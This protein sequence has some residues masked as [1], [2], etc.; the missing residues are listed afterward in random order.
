MK[1]KKYRS[2]SGASDNRS[3]RTDEVCCELEWII[4]VSCLPPGRNRKPFV[5]CV[6]REK[7]P[8]CVK[9]KKT[10]RREK[11]LLRQWKQQQKKRSAWFM[12]KSTLQTVERKKKSYCLIYF[13]IKYIVWDKLGEEKVEPRQIRMFSKTTKKRKWGA[14]TERK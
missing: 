4:G 12:E 6:L 2:V 14:I 11:L 9:R 10:D 8:D 13:W 3:R 7:I 1:S 5:S